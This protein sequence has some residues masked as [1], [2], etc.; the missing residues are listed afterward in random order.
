[1]SKRKVITTTTYCLHPNPDTSNRL[2]DGVYP[3]LWEPTFVC[4]V[5]NAEWDRDEKT[6][7]R[8]AL[9]VTVEEIVE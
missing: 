4:R 6:K 8:Q 3:R 9:S 7:P 2:V 1:M 5:C